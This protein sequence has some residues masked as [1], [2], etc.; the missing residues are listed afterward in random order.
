MGK[1]FD[2]GLLAL[3]GVGV[4]LVYRYL[5]PDTPGPADT[6][7]QGLTGLPAALCNL[8]GWVTGGWGGAPSEPV[9]PPNCCPPNNWGTGPAWNCTPTGGWSGNYTEQPNGW[10]CK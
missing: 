7:C 3:L 4:V 8:G 9:M 1:I 6:T 10:W 2:V 5:Q